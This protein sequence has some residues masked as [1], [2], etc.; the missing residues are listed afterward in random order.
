MPPL[1]EED[2]ELIR[3]FCTDRDPLV[4]EFSDVRNLD[5]AYAEG[6]ED[7]L[8]ECREHG[9]GDVIESMKGL[10]FRDLPTLRRWLQEYSVKRK[11]PFKVRHSYVQR[12]YTVV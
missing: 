2:I 5:S 1:S 10:V 6:R 4:P 8:L 3:R 12:R 11:R 7:E 9:D